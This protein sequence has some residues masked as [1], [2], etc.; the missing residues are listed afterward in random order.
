M[1]PPRAPRK[2]ASRCCFDSPPP[3]P[4]MRLTVLL[5]FQCGGMVHLVVPRPRSAI[6]PGASGLVLRVRSVPASHR[7]TG[8]RVR[9]TRRHERRP[10]SLLN[11]GRHACSLT[12]CGAVREADGGDYSSTHGKGARGK[13]TLSAVRGTRATHTSC[14]SVCAWGLLRYAARFHSRRPLS[15]GLG[16]LCQTATHRAP[17]GAHS[18]HAASRRLRL[19][20]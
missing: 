3:T 10:I 4:R 9:S 18:F 20:I 7:S 14:P 8:G 16:L 1:S 5:Y 12:L 2:E 11:L 19:S 13:C 6:R 17:N 15:P